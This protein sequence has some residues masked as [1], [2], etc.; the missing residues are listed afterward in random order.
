MYQSRV[1]S[2]MYQ[3]CVSKKTK[4]NMGLKPGLYHSHVAQQPFLQTQVAQQMTNQP[5]ILG[6][7]PAMLPSAFSIMPLQD[8]TWNMDTGASSH[9]IS[10]ASNLNTIF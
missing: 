4:V 7:A 1:V 2:G 6:P 9:L 5:G 3:P 10:N 8:P